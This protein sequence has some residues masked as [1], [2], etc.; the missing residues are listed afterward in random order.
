MTIT[1]ARQAASPDVRVDFTP[2]PV[3][4]IIPSYNRVNYLLESITSC[5]A[6]DYP[7][8]RIVVTDDGSTDETV[9]MVQALAE[10]GVE[11][12]QGPHTGAPINRNRGLATVSSPYVVWIGDDDVLVHDVLSR[13]VDALRK[14]PT[15]DVIHGDTMICDAALEPKQLLQGE[16]WSSRSNALI[17]TLFN[18]NVIADAG[19]LISMAVYARAGWYDPAFPKGHDYHL[20]SRAASRCTFRHDPNVGVLWRWHGSNMGLGGGANP[21]A[22][23][24][25]RIV[26]DMWT[27][28]DK[29]LL[30][31]GIDWNTLPEAQHDA[32]GAVAMAERLM[33]EDAW[34]DAFQFVTAALALGAGEHAQTL[35]NQLAARLTDS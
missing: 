29:R 30:F 34:D 3:T 1:A 31:P 26:L 28:F 24:H 15:A 5:L 27:R 13:R 12:V 4:I 9:Q 20:W 7:H 16:D 35:A 25:R 17:S 33:V 11:L 22:D 18:R 10:F 19:S 23:A 6:Q 21:Y 8:R 2:P 32:L 14:F